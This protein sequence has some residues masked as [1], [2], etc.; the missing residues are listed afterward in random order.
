MTD[1]IPLDTPQIPDQIPLG[2]AT[3]PLNEAA[4]STRSTKA[5]MGLGGVTGQDYDSIYSQVTGGGEDSFRQGAATTLNYNMKKQALD[6]VVAGKLTVDDV[7]NLIDSKEPYPASVI[8]Q[9]YSQAYLG[10]VKESSDRMPGNIVS[11]VGQKAPEVIDHYND[12]AS[13]ILGIREYAISQAQNI[14]GDVASDPYFHVPFIKTPLTPEGDIA[15]G[16]RTAPWSSAIN[17]ATLGIYGGLREEY[18]MRGNTPDTS[19]FSGFEGTNLQEQAMEIYNQPTFEAKK[20][21]FDKG[22]NRLKAQDPT[23][24]QQWAMGIV[25]MSYE[26]MVLKNLQSGLN[27]AGGVGAAKGIKTAL[28]SVGKAQLQGI[29]ATIAGGT[30]A[31]LDIPKVQAAMEGLVPGKEEQLPLETPELWAVQRSMEDVLKAAPAHP[32][33]ANVAEAAGDL[34]EA[35]VQKT[36]ANARQPNPQQEAIDTL[37]ALHRTQREDINR[38]SGNLSR[39][40]HTRLLDV[41]DGYEKEAA[42]TLVEAEKI[43]RLPALAENGF[44]D[45]LDRAN[46][47]FRGLENTVLDVDHYHDDISNTDHY[48]VTQGDYNGRAFNTEQQAKNFATTNKYGDV[49]VVGQNP[50]I[51]YFNPDAVFKFAEPGVKGIEAKSLERGHGAAK[52]GGRV[53]LNPNFSFEKDANGNWSFHLTDPDLKGNRVEVLPTV[54]PQPTYVPFN[55]KTGKF[56]EPLAQGP[57]I[58]QK[59]LGW[60]IKHLIPIN[61]QDPLIRDKFLIVNERQKSSSSGRGFVSDLFNGSFLGYFRNPQDTLSMAE[62]ENRGK[63]VYSS[64]KYFKLIMRDMKYVQD[65]YSGLQAGENRSLSYL[66]NLTGRNKQVWTD[67]KRAL[68]VAQKYP[69]PNTGLP[70]YY[71]RTPL[72][73]QHFWQTA[74]GRPASFAEQQAYLAVQRMDY[75]DWI[76]RNIGVYKNKARLGVMEHTLLSEGGIRS[77]PFEGR[78]IFK[79]P[80]STSDIP[81]AVHTKDGSFRHLSSLKGEARKSIEAAFE[82]GEYK[83]VQLYAPSEY[84]VPMQDGKGRPV[85]V[86]YVISNSMETRPI[87]YKQVG[88]RGGGHWDYNYDYYI[89]QPIVRMFSLGGKTHRIYEGDATFAP[90]KNHVDGQ[91]MITNMNKVLIHLRN[92]REAEAKALHESFSDQDWNE[93]K[94]GFS[95]TKDAKTGK[96]SPPRFSLDEDFRVV[97]KGFT[98]AEY[99][100]NFVNVN[101]SL[102]K[103]KFTNAANGEQDLSRNYQVEYTGVR[104]SSDLFEPYNTGTVTNPFYKFQPAELTDPLVAQTRALRRIMQ[105]A[106]GD[107]YKYSAVEHW[108]Q[109]NMD[110]LD[111]ESKE[112][113]RHSPFA[114]FM[115]NDLTRRARRSLLGQA[116]I[117]NRYKIQKL[118]GMPTFM[119]SQIQMV[120]QALADE[121]FKT[122]SKLKKAALI[123]PSWIL[124]KIHS[125]TSFL[126]GMAFHEN[127][128]MFNWMQLASQNA[129]YI[130]FLALSPGH[131]VPGVFGSWMHLWTR[132]NK[133]PAILDAIDRKAAFFGWKPGEFTEAMKLYENTGFNEI[134]NSLAIHDPDAKFLMS[135]AEKVLRVGSKYFFELAEQNVRHGAWYTAYHEYKRAFPTKVIDSLE[136]GKILRRANDLYAN[137]GRDSKTALNTGITSLTLQF[138]KYIENVGQLFLSKR[139]GDVFGKENTWQLRAQQ[140]AQMVAMY[141]LF[142]GP[143]GATGLSLIPANDIIRKQAIANGYVPGQNAWS[144]MLMEGPLSMAGAYASGWWRTGNLDMSKGTF[145]NYN[146]RYGA[147]GYQLLR[148]LLEGSPTFWQVVLGAS[149]STLSNNLAS[150]SPLVYAW[151]AAFNDEQDN[152]FRLT[153]NDWFDGLRNVNSLRYADRLRY[154]IEFGKWLDRHGRPQDDVG[155]IDAIF[156]TLLGVNDVNLDDLYLMRQIQKDERDNYAKAQQDF[157]HYRRLQN[158]AIENGDFE[159]AVAYGKNAIFA[160]HSRGVPAEEASKI[161][162]SDRTLSTNMKQQVYDSFYHKLVPQYRQGGA[163]EAYQA[164]AGQ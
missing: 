89:K 14:Q 22:F 8:E 159:Q 96:I 74:F 102:P 118:I 12:R 111:S 87:S 163:S 82:R 115:S 147:N 138:F 133:S 25:G 151:K 70:G 24:A 126:R 53:E 97:P 154:A 86:V 34:H 2:N 71:F 39:E 141:S 33:P 69:D 164:H 46:E 28:G 6:H 107:D 149:G 85:R 65:L 78:P 156:R 38:F 125:P 124:G 117:S 88:Y 3:A 47:H 104:D 42:Q 77:A 135:N 64:A 134:G 52:A 153:T 45:I 145:Y 72:E 155:K 143:L 50:D 150:L 75:T 54:E 162:R 60:Y 116:A 158:E 5:W 57:H 44:R 136:T 90:I 130:N 17:W 122:D 61:E 29:G 20:A 31:N 105:S 81:V 131:A 41:T 92:K 30:E 94:R 11:T 93:F 148:D 48:A 43:V 123:P 55:T 37:F 23:L 21:M 7:K 95:P 35:A 27:I 132:V 108:L 18:L 4:A 26:D 66:G 99:D 120:K 140:R 106:A 121:I 13:D 129:A 67:F 83:G 113:A 59:G 40:D 49:P 114:T 137:M 127:L 146:N 112:A 128:G 76:F 110:K 119:D 139:I 152:P 91:N 36:L 58:V 80:P 144:T 1:L 63:L 103:T 84:P 16:S 68:T 10:K 9:A 101:K 100:K 160:L 142:F 51:L 32:T 109:E 56:A 15:V 19:R 79:L 98:I 157:Q 73:I 161:F 62:V